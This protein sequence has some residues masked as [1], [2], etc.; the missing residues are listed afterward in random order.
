MYS[1]RTDRIV[2]FMGCFANIHR[3]CF[4]NIHCLPHFTGAAVLGL[5][6][7]GTA[8]T[9]FHCGCVVVAETALLWLYG[10]GGFA[11]AAVL[12]LR[13]CGYTAMATCS[14]ADTMPRQCP[15][16]L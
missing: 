11:R 14:T 3:C 16:A 1:A 4:A 12:W 13:C 5:G 8:W 10:Y 7:A 6:G 2:G 15:F 9:H